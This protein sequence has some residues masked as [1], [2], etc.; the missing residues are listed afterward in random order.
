VTKDVGELAIMTP[1][2]FTV[3]NNYALDV[4]INQH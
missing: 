2:Y 3:N 4:M 1:V